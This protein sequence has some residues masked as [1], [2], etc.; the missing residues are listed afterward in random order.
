MT[1]STT[2]DSQKTARRR[3][4]CYPDTLLT[5]SDSVKLEKARPRVRA[6]KEV[7]KGNATAEDRGKTEG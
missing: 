4:V 2:D 7:K 3:A 1:V 5:K 6:K